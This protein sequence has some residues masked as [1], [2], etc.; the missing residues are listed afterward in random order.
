[1]PFAIKAPVKYAVSFLFIGKLLVE[2][3]DKRPT[4]SFD[5]W[6]RKFVTIEPELYKLY[7][8]HDGQGIKPSDGAL[9]TVVNEDLP[10]EKRDAAFDAHEKRVRRMAEVRATGEK[11]FEYIIIIIIIIYLF[12]K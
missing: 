6:M 4:I 12:I 8:Q 7:F 9:L 2:E 3:D 1:M 5:E 11:S 10:I